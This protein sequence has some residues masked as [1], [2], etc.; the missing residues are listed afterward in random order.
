MIHWS[1]VPPAL[2]A[3]IFLYS[4][5]FGQG[6]EASDFPEAFR[7][8]AVLGVVGMFS[9]LLILWLWSLALGIR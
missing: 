1:Y 7:V 5:F 6:G 8:S 4:L 9:G 3:T 2:F